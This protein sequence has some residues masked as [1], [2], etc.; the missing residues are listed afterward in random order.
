MCAL[1]PEFVPSGR[2][3]HV[4]RSRMSLNPGPSMTRDAIAPR[5]TA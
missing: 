2:A 1:V 4:P 5:Q 3:R